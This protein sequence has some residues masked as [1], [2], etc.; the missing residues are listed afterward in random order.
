MHVGAGEFV[1]A[2]LVVLCGSLVQGTIGFGLNLLAAPFVALVLP[3]ALPVTLVLV[4]WPVG[5]VT[6]VREHHALDRRTLP[7]LLLGAVP[8]TLAGLAIVTRASTDQLAIIVGAVTLLGV[9]LSVVT[10]PIHVGP[11]SAGIAGFVSNVT[12]TAAAV[13]GPPV[14]LLYQ[15]HGGPTV[16]ATLGVFFAVSATLSVAG[17]ALT[18]EITEDRVLLALALLPAMAAGIWTSKHFHGLVDRRWLRPT[19]LTLCAIA[20][21]AAILRGAL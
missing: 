13:G 20:G 9:V 1:V 4:A 16:R 17:Y 6:A 21:T 19:V 10:P 12:G 3:E 14:A 7:W 8:G 11:G 2:A 18:G 15:H 5:A